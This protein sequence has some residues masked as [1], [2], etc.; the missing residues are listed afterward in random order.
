MSIHA[1]ISKLAWNGSKRGYPE[2]LNGEYFF[3]KNNAKIL[4]VP[5]IIMV[6]SSF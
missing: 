6:V 5:S 1:G 4:F 2:K 3:F